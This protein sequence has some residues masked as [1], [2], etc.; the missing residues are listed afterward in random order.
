M[1]ALE[2]VS[3]LAIAVYLRLCRFRAVPEIWSNRERDSR[4]CQCH[5]VITQKQSFFRL[6]RG[7][8]DWGRYCST[9]CVVVYA[10]NALRGL[11]PEVE[12]ILSSVTITDPSKLLPLVPVAG[13]ATKAA[14][15]EHPQTQQRIA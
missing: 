12:V 3:E 13:A 9:G 15:A 8:Q 10:E 11:G 6:L 4:C 2:K 1:S 5:R 14:D 7:E